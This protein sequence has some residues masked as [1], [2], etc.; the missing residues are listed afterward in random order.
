[1]RNRGAIATTDATL[2]HFLSLYNVNFLIFEEIVF[3]LSR[4]DPAIKRHQVVDSYVRR[5]LR[6]PIDV[7][8]LI[9]NPRLDDLGIGNDLRE[10]Y[11][12]IV[13]NYGS[14]RKWRKS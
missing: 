1:M 5:R 12:M 6:K 7:T 10:V 2:D 14:R 11:D 9:Q 4:Q 13:L 3:A 8:V